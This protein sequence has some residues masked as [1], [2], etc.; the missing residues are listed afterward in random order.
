[1]SGAVSRLTIEAREVEN[2]GVVVTTWL[3]SAQ[4]TQHL[5]VAANKPLRAEELTSE[6]I[7]L[8]GLEFRITVR[9]Q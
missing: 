3:G 9:A 7:I 1:M 8:A 4:L 6:P 2:M 5:I